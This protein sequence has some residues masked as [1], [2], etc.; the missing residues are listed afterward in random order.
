MI[1]EEIKRIKSD[2]KD[3]RNFGITMGIALGVIG[4]LLLWRDKPSYFY[5]VI[6]AVAFLLSGFVFPAVLKPF[7]KVWMAISILMG[8]FMT[9]VILIVLFY[10]ILTPIG[11]IG[12]LCGKDFLDIKLHK[13]TPSY[14]VPRDK[15]EYDKKSYEQQ[16]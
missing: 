9:R 14:W 4:G 13:N 12:R 2:R 1:L 11:L 15:Q 8:W 10:G 7:Q 16:F 5:C 6:A 3:L